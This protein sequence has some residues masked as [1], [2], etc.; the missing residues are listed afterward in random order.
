MHP[1]HI[2]DVLWAAGFTGHIALLIVLFAR[3]HARTF[4]FFTAY[5]LDALIRTPTLF[6]VLR[7][8]T[9]HAYLIAYVSFAI[10]D[11]ALQ[12]CIAYELASHV[13]CPA[14]RWPQG[15]RMGASILVGS[16]IAI[17][18]GLT[19]LPIPP[20]HSLWKTILDHANL[21]SSALLCELL[22]GMIGF[23]V[24]ASLP[25]KANVARI[26]QGLGFYSFVGL[27][28]E[29]GHNVV[30]MVRTHTLSHRLTLFREITYITCLAYWAVT[31]W[32]KEQTP[33]EM[34]EKMR[35]QLF[36]LQMRLEYDLRKLRLL[37]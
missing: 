8:E 19:M 33:E 5:I 30:G 25:W 23:A 17:A 37:K 6:W 1:S 31:L 16:S 29:A 10:V 22:I 11:Q 28:T 36:T 15:T 24:T 14:G 20:E 21:F 4:P 26:A 18:A 32:H 34:P 3:G 35:M 12:L 27:L 2:E 9:K 7:N 13:F